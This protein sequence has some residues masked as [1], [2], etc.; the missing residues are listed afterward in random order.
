MKHLVVFTLAFACGTAAAA[1]IYTPGG[2]NDPRVRSAQFLAGNSRYLSA[3][4]LLA[5]VQAEAPQKRFAPPYYRDLAADTLSFGMPQRAEVIYR[6]EIANAKDPMSLARARLRLAD[7]FY[8]RSYYQQASTELSAVRAQLPKELL[9]DWQDL[10]SRVLLGQGRY[11]E[12]ADILTQASSSDMT[13]IMRYNL[14][15][16]LVNDGRVGQGVNMLDRVGRLNPTDSDSLALRDK[17]N[18]TLGYHFLRTQQGGTAVPIFGRV[19]TVGPYSNRALLGL[20][21]AYLAPRGAKQK[22]AEL[23]DEAPQDGTAFTSFATI[24]VLL[25]PGYIDSDSIY[26]RAKLAPFHLSGRSADEEAQL[27]QALVPWVELTSRDTIDPA[28]QEGLLAIPYVLDRL[29]AHIQAQ[30]YYERAIDALEETHTRLDAAEQH[31]RSGRMVK[32]MIDHDPSAESG[33]MWK[34]KSLPDAPETFYLQTLLADNPFQEA[35]KNFRDARMLQMNLQFWK[36][37]MAELQSSYQTRSGQNLPAAPGQAARAPGTG[38]SSDPSTAAS[39]PP[40]QLANRL[41]AYN[42]QSSPDVPDAEAPVTLHLAQN[43]G[44]EKFFGP[45]ER[46]QALRT[47]IDALMPQLEAAENTQ[48]QLLQDIA[49]GD[50]EKQK[51]VNQKLLAESRFALARI[52]DSQLKGDSK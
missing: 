17:A 41:S 11:G 50:L 30:Q 27:K 49:L 36:T 34:L 4:A 12:A 9:I 16:A 31:V 3:A 37:R 46:M 47:R 8:Q 33:W 44:S 48:G 19:R 26:K 45:F 13:N 52:Y 14:G 42:G 10:Q 2:D 35:L 5:Q 20:G 39:A 7:F 51:I 28:V 29:G 1:D 40:L 23:G 6:E 21:W 43:P 25:R 22:K 38:Y 32:T 24:G 15:V 18:L